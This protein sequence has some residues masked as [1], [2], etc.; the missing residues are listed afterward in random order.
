M[1]LPTAMQICCHEP[2]AQGSPSSVSTGPPSPI[3]A[4]EGNLVGRQSRNETIAA[5]QRWLYGALFP[6]VPWR[7]KRRDES[8][9]RLS[10]RVWLQH[11]RLGLYRPT[12]LVLTSDTLSFGTGISLSVA[13]L[14]VEADL[15]AYEMKLSNAGR[16]AV[17]V[18]CQTGDD[19][20]K[21]LQA[22]PPTSAVRRASHK[23]ALRVPALVR[24]RPV[25]AGLD[26][27]EA[28]AHPEPDASAPTTPPAPKS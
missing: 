19:M 26:G 12:L 27:D 3:S 14:T 15:T 4:L 6:G 2:A 24:V 7:R 9:S 28:L 22:L 1:S 5:Q 21:W 20:S 18:R 11:K 16:Q 13:G 23:H 8:D 25:D 10:G 17:R